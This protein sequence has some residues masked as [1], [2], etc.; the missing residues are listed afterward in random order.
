[1][2]GNC[3]FKF[4]YRRRDSCPRCH[5]ATEKMTN[6]KFLRYTYYHCTKRK[7]P[8]CSQECLSDT[9]LEQQIDQYL[10][11]IQISE[12]FKEWAVKYLHELHAKYVFSGEMLIDDK[13]ETVERWCREHP[14]GR[15]VLW[16]QPYNRAAATRQ[17][18]WSSETFYHVTGGNS[19][20]MIP[21]RTSDWSCVCAIL[22][23]WRP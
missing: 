20:A 11:H 4:A 6:A 13:P 9:E 10:A 19:H 15:G 21:F 2:C 17:I 12:K 23:E 14:N 18:L 3:R 5:V 16:D 7:H 1:M 8:E 22:H